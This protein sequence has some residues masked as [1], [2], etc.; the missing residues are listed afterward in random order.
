MQ[1]NVYFVKSCR[2]KVK[3]CLVLQHIYG[4]KL[5]YTPKNVA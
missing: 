4:I 1:Y 5:I 3:D 2:N